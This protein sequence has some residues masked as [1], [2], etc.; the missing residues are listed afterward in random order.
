MYL[1][2]DRRTSISRYWTK[3]YG[4]SKKTDFKVPNTHNQYQWSAQIVVRR[5]FKIN[6]ILFL[7]QWPPSIETKFI[8][9]TYFVLTVLRLRPRL[10]YSYNIEL[11]RLVYLT[12]NDD[13]FV[14][15]LHN[16]QQNYNVRLSR[17]RRNCW[18]KTWH[19]VAVSF[20]L[21]SINFLSSS[22]LLVF[23]VLISNFTYYKLLR[24][25]NKS[26]GFAHHRDADNSIHIV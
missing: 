15:Q 14:N 16:K 21:R 2:K 12:N 24:K 9:Y 26:N 6:I 17:Q 13:I 10:R 18:K 20:F 3:V 8:L 4:R 25:K 1:K 7:I 19:C 11:R 22:V 5:T 23:T